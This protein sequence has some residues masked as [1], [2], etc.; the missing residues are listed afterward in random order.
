MEVELVENLDTENVELSDP[1]EQ[2]QEDVISDPSPEVITEEPEY[3]PNYSFKVRNEEM[4]FDERLKPLVTSK[5]VEDHLRDLHTKAHGLDY[6]K[7]G[8]D[9][10]TSEI[11]KLSRI[12]HEYDDMKKGFS[13]LGEMSK[14]DFAIFQKSLKIP[15]DIILE[16]AS[17]II[18][19]NDSDSY[20]REKLD[21]EYQARLESYNQEGTLEQLR[22]QN[23]ELQR[24]QHSLA[25][26]QAM[27]DSKVSDFKEMFDAK[28]GKGSFESEVAQ[29]GS[30]IYQT[31]KRYVDPEHVIKT[32]I[33]RYQPLLGSSDGI[34]TQEPQSKKLAP[35]PL[36]SLNSGGNTTSPTKRRFKSFDEMRKYG[37]E[38]HRQELLR[39]Y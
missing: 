34:S 39:Q 24:R 9:E 16:R 37:E 22:S 1:I 6:L 18:D 13:K 25:Y 30:L 14:K 3:S 21:R 28:M 32:V 10:K 35:K 11:E 33:G 29:Y 8:L 5:D 15:D 31:E 19:Y 12:Q 2:P 20:N 27:S 23:I 4:Q 36:P 17:Q 38:L 26:N 7:K